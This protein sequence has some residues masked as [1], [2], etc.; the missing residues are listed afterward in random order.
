MQVAADVVLE[1][2]LACSAVRAGDAS[3][4]DRGAD[5]SVILWSGSVSGASG[6][7]HPS[8]RR[9]PLT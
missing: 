1:F 3:A 2:S 5:D 4:R 7:P 8:A 6:S 9:K